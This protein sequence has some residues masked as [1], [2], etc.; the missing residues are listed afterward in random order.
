MPHLAGMEWIRSTINPGD[1]I[2]R[3]QLAP[4]SQNQDKDQMF[5]PVTLLPRTEENKA[6]IQNQR[7]SFEL[8][9][10]PPSEVGIWGD[11]GA[12]RVEETFPGR[13]EGQARRMMG[14]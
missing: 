11:R 3:H 13:L 7:R 5:L 4:T 6:Y 14:Y 10:P 8:G 12:V 9:F 2:L 1:V